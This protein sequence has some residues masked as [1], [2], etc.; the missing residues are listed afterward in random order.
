MISNILQFFAQCWGISL[1]RLQSFEDCFGVIFRMSPRVNRLAQVAVRSIA[2][3]E[4]PIGRLVDINACI[5]KNLPG[6]NG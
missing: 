5:R 4:H 3:Q 6:V 1:E 2:C